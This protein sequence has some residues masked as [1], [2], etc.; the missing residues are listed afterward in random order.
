MSAQANCPACGS[1]VTFGISTSLATVCPSC[2]SIVA[3]TDRTL[4][5][6]GKVAE[7]SESRSPLMLGLR[8]QYQGRHF[9]L[10][11]RAQL[12][13]AAGGVW[14]EWYAA[15]DDG[16]WGWLAEAMGRFF[17][18]FPTPFS[19]GTKPPPFAALHPGSFFG[20]LRATPV[21]AEKSWVEFAAAEGELPFPLVPGTRYA[22]ADLSGPDGQFGTLDYSRPEPVY[23][24]GREATLAELGLADAVEKAGGV[25]TVSAV[26]VSC[27][28]CGGA[29]E[30]RAPDQ[31]QRVA[32]PYCRSLLDV[33]HGEL[34]Y[35]KTLEPQR[36]APILPLG[37]SAEF[38]G[39]TFTVIGFV[40]R[41]T[42][43]E[44]TWWPWGEYLLYQPKVGYRWLVH[45]DGH[46]TWVKALPPGEVSAGTTVSYKGRTFKRFQDAPA[47][48]LH[49][50]G[51]FYWKVEA[52]E[53]VESSDYVCAPQ[54][55]SHELARYEL[56]GTWGVKKDESLGEVNWSLGEYVP[57]SE[58]RRKFPQVK[59]HGPSTVG[60]CQ[61]FPHRGIYRAWGLLTAAAVALILFT[62]MISPSR[63][64]LE[65]TYQFPQLERS[66]GTQVLF[67]DP[68]DLKSGQNICVEGLSPVD[69]SWFFV[70]GE[71]VKSGQETIQVAFALPIEYYHGVEDGE[72][73]S[74]GCDNTGD[75][76]SAIEPGVYT[77]R[78]EACWEKWRTP[79]ILKL[80]IRQGVPRMLNG[81]L[82]LIAISIVPILIFIWERSFESRRWQES[83]YG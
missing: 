38:E 47:R 73:W 16:V 43:I 44:G 33:N 62:R 79:A 52:G 20:S 81:L 58:V 78:M 15:F 60:A 63:E 54:I 34:V 26:K 71:L 9:R 6:L 23:F 4:Q 32:C 8:G 2:R 75:F 83:M 53:T 59:I 49:V 39:Q 45:S 11:G 56:P 35:L 74:V 25:K 36:H 5:S 13:H 57:V 68:F 66:D 17:I 14:D 42:R 67:T 72:S 31:T 50:S 65:Q 40:V 76:F 18:T 46:W 82:V 30:L 7:L 55:L 70:H 80:H 29:L 1:I 3:R 21:V 61:P 28:H 37:A 51:E 27:P 48:V 77:L 12:N 24:S 41:A 19:A 69:N 22:Y 10:V 64:V